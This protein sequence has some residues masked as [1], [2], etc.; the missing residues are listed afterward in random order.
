MTCESCYEDYEDESEWVCIQTCGHWCCK[1]CYTYHLQSNLKKGRE[2]VETF[3][4]TGG[5]CRLLVP[6]YV[7]SDLLKGA[8]LNKYRDL[9]V[10]HYIMQQKDNY[11]FCPGTDCPA[12]VKK[13]TV[14]DLWDFKCNKCN[15]LFCFECSKQA[16]QPIDCDLLQ[17]WMDRMGNEDEDSQMWIKL[18]TKPCPKCKTIIEKNQGCMHMT[19]RQCKHDFCWLCMGDYRKHQQETGT[20]L[21]SSYEQVQKLGRAGPATD[22]Q[23]AEMELKRYEF[24][25]E[26]YI[27]HQ[28]SVKFGKQKLDKIK[29]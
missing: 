29:T 10:E 2:C 16:H 26:R 5:E 12:I 17:Q 3:C 9:S 11:K 6:E 8:E 4:P 27:N 13:L 20:Y 14:D 23:K 7:W 18:N 22:T 21:C 24:Y 19:C 25:S 28:N 15:G 1:D